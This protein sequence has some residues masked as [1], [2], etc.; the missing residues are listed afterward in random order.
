MLEIEKK[1]T[2]PE[3]L[4]IT[5]NSKIMSADQVAVRLLNGM[6]KNKFEVYCNLE[7]RFIRWFRVVAPKLYFR[8]LDSVIRKDRIKRGVL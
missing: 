4:A 3:C 6:K 1:E 7:G 8:K 5:K 2:L